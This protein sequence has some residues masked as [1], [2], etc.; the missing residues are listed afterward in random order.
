M[1]E[2]ILN[3][4]EVVQKLKETADNYKSS[5][6]QYNKKLNEESEIENEISRISDD[7]AHL[8]K[9][10]LLSKDEE[11]K[12]LEELNDRYSTEFSDTMNIWISDKEAVENSEKQ[13]KDI[14][15]NI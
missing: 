7:I 12:E 10:I 9:G 4:I 13:D 3:Y 14:V 2:G 6:E 8:E 15:S 1:A 11:K 5:Y